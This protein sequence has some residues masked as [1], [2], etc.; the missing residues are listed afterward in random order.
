MMNTNEEPIAISDEMI[1]A[2]VVAIESTEPTPEERQAQQLAKLIPAIRE[3]IQRGDSEDKIRKKLK[4]FGI[5][6]HHRKLKKLF[7]AA[8]ASPIASDEQLQ[9]EAA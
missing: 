1:S 5:N 8:A 3:A 9:E 7:D 2:A 6:L 4:A